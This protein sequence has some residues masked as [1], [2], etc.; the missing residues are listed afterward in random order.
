MPEPCVCAVVLTCNRLE[1]SRRCIE[2]ILGQTRSPDRVLVVDNGSTDGTVEWVTELSRNDDR[3]ALLPLPE[4]LGPAGGYAEGFEWAERQG[5]DAIWAF[6]DDVY[7]N[8]DCL[9]TLLRELGDSDDLVVYPNL[10]DEGTGDS[11]HYPAWSGVVI[12][13]GIVRNAGVPERELFWWIEDTEYLQWRL[14]RKHGVRESFVDATHAIHGIHVKSAKSAWKYYYEVR[15]TLWYRLRIQKGKPLRRAQRLLVV[16]VS[17]LLRPVLTE[18]NKLQK[19]RYV[20]LGI[21]HGLQGRLG[22]TVDPAATS[23]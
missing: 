19:L 13:M 12:P 6:A 14:P 18:R 21:L 23:R 15:N 11:A 5:F 1:K 10:I 16:V 17:A 20:L 9:E 22:K 7:P 2:A 4:N 8:R 3:V